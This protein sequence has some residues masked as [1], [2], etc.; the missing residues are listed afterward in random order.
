VD[1]KRSPVGPTSGPGAF[2][3]KITNWTATASGFPVSADYNGLTQPYG[4]YNRFDLFVRPDGKRES[5]SR[6][7][8][9][10]GVMNPDGTGVGSRKLRVLFKSTVTRILFDGCDAIGVEFVQEGVMKRAYATKEIILAG[11]VFSAQIL[12]NSGVGD[13]TSL[14]SLGIPVVFNNPNVGENLSNHPYVFLPVGINPTDTPT[15]LP[16][17]SGLGGGFFLP[18]WFANLTY[19]PADLNL[20]RKFHNAWVTLGPGLAGAIT[21]LM[22]P[23][24]KGYDRVQSNDPFQVPLHDE[25]TFDNPADADDF[26]AF[27]YYFYQKTLFPY[28]QS[29]DASYQP[30]GWGQWASVADAKAWL[31]SNTLVAAHYNGQNKMGTSVATG[32]VVNWEGRVFGV[33]GVRV[34]DSTI[35]PET[36]DGNSGAVTMM[37]GSRIAD[38][39]LAE[40]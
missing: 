35:I 40:Y 11:S 9:D 27:L 21:T 30:L 5:S 39:I 20:P 10:D 22:Q 25:K 28:L 19:N 17:H 18:Q 2:V 4:P 24:S 23:K 37:I 31:V 26:A 16:D 3:S 33:N 13:A 7:F 32:A 36:P 12:Q 38:F 1:V 15:T 14:S 8:L 34:A 29:K 6:A